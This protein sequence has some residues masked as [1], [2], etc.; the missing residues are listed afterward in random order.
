[1]SPREPTNQT[2]RPRGLRPV[3][4]EE[5]GVEDL[6]GAGKLVGVVNAGI[7]PI[8]RIGLM[9]VVLAAFIA[10]AVGYH[11]HTREDM[12]RMRVFFSEQLD[13]VERTQREERAEDRRLFEKLNGNMEKLTNSVER[14][15]PTKG[16]R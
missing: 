14:M 3:S 4:A 16:S 10:L 2:P 6:A 7:K 13:K 12:A 11:N 1:M 8:E 15:H 5:Y 9:A